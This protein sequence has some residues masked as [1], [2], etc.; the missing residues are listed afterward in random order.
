MECT[1]IYTCA[2]CLQDSCIGGWA[3]VF[4]YADGETYR[5]GNSYQETS[6]NLMSLTAVIKALEYANIA[7]FDSVRIFSESL[8]IVNGVTKWLQIWS[9]NDWMTASNK[10]VKHKDMWQRLRCLLSNPVQVEWIQSDTN[11]RIENIVKTLADDAARN[12]V[13]VYE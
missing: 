3:V 12:D 10:P 11:T 8:Y 13:I 7:K 4:A 2:A 6:S 9:S 5:W 1:D